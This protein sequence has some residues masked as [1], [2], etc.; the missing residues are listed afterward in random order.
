M[1]NHET[2]WDREL[3]AQ[4]KSGLGTSI[5]VSC[6]IDKGQILPKSFLWRKH[7]FIVE[8]VNFFWKDKKGREELYFFSLQTSEGA[9]EAVFAKESLSWHLKRLIGP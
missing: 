4:E 1:F 3:P 8:K 5:S 7:T 2:R 6:V 9:Y